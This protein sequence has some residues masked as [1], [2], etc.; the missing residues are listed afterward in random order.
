MNYRIALAVVPLLLAAACNN[1]GTADGSASAATGAK[2]AAKAPPAGQ[3]WTDIVAATPEGGVRMGNPDAPI[4]LVE[5]GS[6]SCP[7]CAKF[8]REGFPALKAGA[9][10]SGK[11][12]YEFRDYPVHGALDI[13]PIM[14]GNCVEPAA[15][16]PMLQQMMENQES[17]LAKASSITPAENQQLAGKS[18]NEVAAFLADRLGYIDFVKQRGVAETRARTCLSDKTALTRLSQNIQTANE[19]YN[20][21]G[22]PTFLINGVVQENT[23]E[24]SQLQPKLAA[25]GI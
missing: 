2:V 20:I 8:D 23:G 18:P 13:G 14:L 16:F 3:S 5:Y 19:R 6:R 9:I 4:K 15:F 11:L 25:A 12:S 24:W 10:A 22:T 7:H 21:S 1:G 17:L